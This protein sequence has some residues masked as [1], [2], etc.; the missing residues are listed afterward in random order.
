MMTKWRVPRIFIL[1]LLTVDQPISVLSQSEGTPVLTLEALIQ[2]ALMKNPQLLAARQKAAA[3]SRQIPQARAWDAPSL[4]VEFYNTP[5]NTFDVLSKGMETDYFL[6]QMLPFP[7]KLSAMGSMAAFNTK[8]AEAGV[9][10]VERKIIADV[11][12]AYYELYFNQKKSEINAENRDLVQ[13]MAD[14]ANQQFAVGMGSQQDVLKAQVELSK[15]INE[16]RILEQEKKVIVAMLN[17]L[18]SRPPETPM[19]AVPEIEP[20]GDEFSSERL[21]QMALENRPELKA[22]SY[23]VEMSRA[24]KSLAR[25]EYYP[26]LMVKLT[27]KRMPFAEMDAWA[28]MFQVNL[29]IAFWSGG[30]YRNRVQETEL[31]IS[32]SEEEY[33]AMANMTRFEVTQALT[34]LQTSRGTL[35][36]YKSSLIP[37]A[38]QTLRSTLTAY[39]TGKVDFLSLIDSYR[40]LTM[41]RLDYYMAVMQCLKSQAELERV[42]GVALS[43]V[44]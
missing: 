15:L 25:R 29:P 2:E 12:S 21:Q 7:G 16:G 41:T 6:Q 42:V 35:Q 20:I 5:I 3:A 22:M 10:A 31:T 33:R 36:L 34:Q 8:I 40:M 39:Q 18:L 43:Q 27:Y 1:L 30:K 32:Q 23:N 24:G 9:Q 44:K 26:D 17:T 13:K 11:K 19:P 37:Q 28:A 14:I 4:G 38:E